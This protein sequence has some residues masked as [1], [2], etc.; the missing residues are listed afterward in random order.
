VYQDEQLEE[1]KIEGRL[2]KFRQVASETLLP[3]SGIVALIY[4]LSP[5]STFN[6]I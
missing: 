6:Y 2:N 3:I 4:G 5:A 1:W